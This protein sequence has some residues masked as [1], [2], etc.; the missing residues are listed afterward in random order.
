LYCTVLQRC[1]DYAVADEFGELLTQLGRAFLWLGLTGEPF[2][3]LPSGN[4]RVASVD[5]RGRELVEVQLLKID[6]G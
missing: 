1:P 4:S 2:G 6:A 5:D 3:D